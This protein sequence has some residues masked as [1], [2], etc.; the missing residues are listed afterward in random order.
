MGKFVFNVSFFDHFESTTGRP[1]SS[2]PLSQVVGR[3]AARGT[4]EWV[5]PLVIGLLG[6]LCLVLTL[7]II[8][9][10]PELA[11]RFVGFV[12]RTFDNLMRRLG[13]NQEDEQE[14]AYELPDYPAFPS[15]GRPLAN[16][17]DSERLRR[18][19]AV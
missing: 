17:T 10:K 16:R 11:D 4:P 2:T 9:L 15:S 19:S 5:M 13:R 18:C 1:V 3:E 14:Q 6:T 12:L 7:V 8:K